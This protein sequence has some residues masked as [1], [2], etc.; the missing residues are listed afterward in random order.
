MRA[1]RIR[2]HHSR[3]PRC[4]L[5]REICICPILPTVE[6]RTE[7]IILRH[8]AEE[9]R[10]S[11]TGRLVALA[12]PNAR[13]V[14]CGGGDRVGPPPL[15][16]D[17]LK[18]PGTRLLWPDGTGIQSEMP[19]VRTADRVV[20]LD[21]TWRQARKMYSRMP[22]LWMLPRLAL[23]EPIG[24]R[25]RLRDQHRPDGMSTIEAVAAALARL[26]GAEKAYPLE[27]LYDE[28]VRRSITLRWGS[29]PRYACSRPLDRR[30]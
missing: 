24:T 23:P 15:D 30:E 28:V 29:G 2:A 22:V 12:M 14:P 16:A 13:I 8:I 7:F 9:E 25:D 4:Y 17:L 19:E 5:R 20:V 18:A 26:E 6:T 11:N 10:P 21:A 3:C 27:R 1:S